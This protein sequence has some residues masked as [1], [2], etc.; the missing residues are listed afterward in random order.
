MLKKWEDE[1]LWWI[2]AISGLMALASLVAIPFF[3]SRI[4]TD[5][6]IAEN[7]VRSGR[8]FLIALSTLFKNI[9]GFLFV[10]A[11]LA[12]LV[13]PGQG[14]ITLIIGLMLM[15]FPGKK[16]LLLRII[17]KPAILSTI[18]AIRAKTKQPPL[19]MPDLPIAEEPRKTA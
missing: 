12:M 7:K 15:N 13:L 6:F 3:L 10:L 4:P 8:P 18:N 19:A 2:G 17:Q 9:L 1:F 14:L 5:Y 11:G 16:S